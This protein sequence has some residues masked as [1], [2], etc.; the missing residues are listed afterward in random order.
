M[1]FPPWS[2]GYVK[3]NEF[4]FPWNSSKSGMHLLCPVLTK[5]RSLSAK[6]KYESSRFKT[7]LYL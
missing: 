1:I 6:E 3:G 2:V 4:H 5:K 7:V